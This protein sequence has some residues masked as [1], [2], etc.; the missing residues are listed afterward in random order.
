MRLRHIMAQ[1]CAKWKL[2]PQARGLRNLITMFA[3]L[4]DHQK[5]NVDRYLC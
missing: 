3:E 1:R 2:D 5:R 4:R